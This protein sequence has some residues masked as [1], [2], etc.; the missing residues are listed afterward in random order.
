MGLIERTQVL[1]M[2][3]DMKARLNQNM[4]ENEVVFLE[5][6]KRKIER[7]NSA[8]PKSVWIPCDKR[9]PETF[10]MDSKGKKRPNA[11]LVT[12]RS[13]FDNNDLVTSSMTAVHVGDGKW[14]WYEPV[15]VNVYNMQNVRSEIVAWQPLPEPYQPTTLETRN[16]HLMASFTRVD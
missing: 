10:K 2:L 15:F 9:L 7:F 13:V 14:K 12:F 6:L 1:K 8:K 4:Q 16:P 3:D 11:V 5:I